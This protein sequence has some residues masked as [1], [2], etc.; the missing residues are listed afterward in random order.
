LRQAIQPVAVRLSYRSEIVSDGELEALIAAG[1][2]LS[3]LRT[4]REEKPADAQ[5][6]LNSSQRM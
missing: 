2:T 1:A 6:P 5:A 3:R 4:M